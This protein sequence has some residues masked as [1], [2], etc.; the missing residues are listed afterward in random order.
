MDS[1]LLTDRTATWQARVEYRT[2]YEDDEEYDEDEDIGVRDARTAY[3]EWALA[4]LN[5]HT[6]EVDVRKT[7]ALVKRA[8]ATIRLS[9]ER[10]QTKRK[11]RERL[12]HLR[13]RLR[14][15]K[16]E[17]KDARSAVKDAERHYEAELRWFEQFGDS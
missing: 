17:L 9:A 15:L 6:V 3:T 12:R 10:P 13:E 4:L 5:A 2:A 16:S 11:R 7:E 8:A 14:D 1:R